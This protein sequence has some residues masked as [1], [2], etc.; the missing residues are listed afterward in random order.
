MAAAAGAETSHPRHLLWTAR[1][2]PFAGRPGGTWRQARVWPRRLK[3]TCKRTMA[4]HH[5]NHSIASVD[6][7]WGQS[8]EV[9]TGILCNCSHTKLPVCSCGGRCAA[10]VW[11]SVSSRGHAYTKWAQDNS[12]LCPQHLQMQGKWNMQD[13][14]EP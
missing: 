13:F 2:V 8:Y 1:D 11:C 9:T 12:Q 3:P 5:N 6:E 14:A 7:P 10:N 4:G